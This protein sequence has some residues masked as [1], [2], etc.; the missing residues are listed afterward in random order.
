MWVILE[1]ER[2]LYTVGHYDPKGKFIPLRDF[3]EADEA[4]RYVHWLNG[5]NSEAFND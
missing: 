5:G 2:G 4:C 3:S 1:P